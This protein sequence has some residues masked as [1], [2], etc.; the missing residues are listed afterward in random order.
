MSVALNYRYGNTPGIGNT[1]TSGL[2]YAGGNAVGS[3]YGMP[4]AGAV[5]SQGY[6]QFVSQMYTGKNKYHY[7]NY[8]DSNVWKPNGNS[9]ITGS[10]P[11]Q[12]Y[13]RP[14]NRHPVRHRKSGQRNF[15]I[16][17]SM[18]RRK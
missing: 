2:L 18:R 5:A 17:R 10:S 15:G 16:W 7:Q 12:N 9:R 11:K 6:D 3:L 14:S 1:L 8:G 4:Y 13:G